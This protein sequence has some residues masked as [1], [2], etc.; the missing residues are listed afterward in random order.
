MKFPIKTTIAV[1][2][3]GGAAA[4]GYT[5]A[6]D[7]YE[8]HYGLKF[9]EVEVSRG[10]IVSV[11]DATGTVQPVLSV[12]VGSFVSGPIEGLFVDF[13]DTVTK[14]QLLAKIDPRL[15]QANVAR[16]RATLSTQKAGVERAKA[17][18]QQARNDEARSQALRKEN[19]NFISDAEMDQFKFN[20]M[21]LEA[22]L[23]VAEASVEQAEANLKN[24]VANLDYT[25][26]R[27][28]VDGI[29]INRKI[30]Q[31]QTL[32]AQ[33]Q[34]P[35]LFIVAPDMRSRMHILASVDEAD[36]GL[37]REAQ[38]RQ[39]PVR[40]TV[41]AYPDDLFTGEI[42]QIRMSSTTT[43]NVVTYPVIV[44]APN[45]DLKLMPGMTASISFQIED[46]QEVLR[47][48]NAA[49]RFYPQREQVRTEDRSILDGA[50][51]E[52]MRNPQEDRDSAGT[53]QSALDKAEARRNRHHRHVW[54]LEGKK[55]KAI[56]VTTGVSD[57]KFT[58]LV[59]GELVEGQKLVT[60]IK[61]TD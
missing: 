21:S 22:Q 16:D 8:K 37:I 49:M 17:Q 52:R 14:G 40:F 32:A 9:R 53:R 31:G 44:A 54:V 34:T 55:L 33:F 7:Y 19:K 23:V 38:R 59:H 25:D 50:D 60:G 36:I 11:V 26:I 56:E 10:P 18:L 1:L 30:D 48:P 13:N 45:P 6:R 2:V 24:S 47:I 29:I 41:D 27:S 12:S 51:G 5:P 15:Y 39:L 46:T 3:L 20:R 4:A 42:A 57:H 61:R 58:A 43:Q 35:E 28:P